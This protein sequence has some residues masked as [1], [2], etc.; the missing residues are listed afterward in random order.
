ML[1]CEDFAV[2]EQMLRLIIGQFGK[3]TR[4]DLYDIVHGFPERTSQA[5]RDCALFAARAGSGKQRWNR[6]KIKIITR[7][8]NLLR[9]VFADIRRNGISSGPISRALAG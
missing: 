3:K 8:I 5:A 9:E 1:A 6:I 7:F 4:S 2:N